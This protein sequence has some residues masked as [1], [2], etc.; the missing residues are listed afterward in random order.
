MAYPAGVQEDT[1]MRGS[2]VS[3]A[4]RLLDEQKEA[5]REANGQWRHVIEFRYVNTHNKNND[6]K[7]TFLHCQSLRTNL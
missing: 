1:T 5:D 2:V 4:Q 7:P 3:Q 6:K